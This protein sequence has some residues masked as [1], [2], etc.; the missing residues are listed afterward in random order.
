[1][2]LDLSMPG[3]DGVGVARRLRADPQCA[4]MCI[5]A[6]TGHAH[7]GDFRRSREAGFDAHLVKPLAPERLCALLLR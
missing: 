5:D 3:L 7:E 4:G 1:M 6:V 2:L